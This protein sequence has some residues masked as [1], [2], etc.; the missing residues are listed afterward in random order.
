MYKTSEYPIYI[1]TVKYYNIQTI[2][3]IHLLGLLVMLVPYLA[4]RKKL[5]GFFLWTAPK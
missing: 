1:F 2:E 5:T 4:R 3:Q